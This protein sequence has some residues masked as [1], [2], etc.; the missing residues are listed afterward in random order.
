MSETSWSRDLSGSPLPVDSLARL[1]AFVASLA[2]D[3]AEQP[4]QLEATTYLS[5]LAAAVEAENQ[6]GTWQDVA[7]LLSGCL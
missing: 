7:T 3:A 6:A 4:Q 1:A 2:P 5:R